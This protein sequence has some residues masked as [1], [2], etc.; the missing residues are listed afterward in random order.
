MKRIS[1]DFEAGPTPGT[2]IVVVTM[3]ILGVMQTRR[4]G[5]TDDDAR[6][7]MAK[8]ATLLEARGQKLLR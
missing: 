7:M 4:V 5:V 3:P 6:V 8:V 2:L 1:L